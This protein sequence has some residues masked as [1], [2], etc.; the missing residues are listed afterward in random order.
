MLLHV[1]PEVNNAHLALLDAEKR[2]QVQSIIDEATKFAEKEHRKK[3][4]CCT[5]VP[6]PI[7]SDI[8]LQCVFTVVSVCRKGDCGCGDGVQV[9]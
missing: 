3:V 6:V 4:G 9:S 7:F 5:T 2:T 1:R 8:S